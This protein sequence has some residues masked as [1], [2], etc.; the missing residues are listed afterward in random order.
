[1]AEVGSRRMTF[2]EF[3]SLGAGRR[4]ELVDGRLEELVP[5][6]PF[7]S[8]TGAQVAKE[9]GRYLEAREP[10]AFWGVELDIPTVQGYGRRPDFAYYSAAA[11]AS[12]LDLQ[13][14]RVLGVPTL[15]VEVVSEEDERR[16]TVIKRA[17]YARAGIEHYW[18]LDPQT[19]SALTLVLRGERYQ[20]A[21]EF[22][23]VSTLT[24]ELF[25]GLEIPLERVFRPIPIPPSS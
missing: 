10:A 4:C 21:G 12:G 23:G 2:E 9:V 11:A 16:D 22:T 25:P 3:A 18:I 14:N 24:S 13:Q 6:R 5:P 17:E 19:H 7:H 1:M 15:V 8:W 20:V